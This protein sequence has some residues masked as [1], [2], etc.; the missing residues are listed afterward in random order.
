MYVYETHIFIFLHLS[1]YSEFCLDVTLNI[2]D[3]IQTHLHCSLLFPCLISF[4]AMLTITILCNLCLYLHSAL[5]FKLLEDRLCLAQNYFVLS[6][7]RHLVNTW[8]M[9]TR[10]NFIIILKLELLKKKKHA[11]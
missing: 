8:K 2:L 1:Q 11:S 4:K 6:Q 9:I 3:K 5:D 7:N 10:I